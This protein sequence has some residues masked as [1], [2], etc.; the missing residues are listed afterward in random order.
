M[1]GPSPKVQR[2]AAD[3][4]AIASVTSEILERIPRGTTP[5]EFFGGLIRRAIDEILTLNS[6]RYRIEQLD[7][8]EQTYIG[9]RAEIL[10]KEALDVG[11]GLRADALIAE[12]EVDLKWSKRLDWM[13]G[14]ENLGTV[15]LGIGTDPL[16]KRFSVGLFVPHADL[17][18][19]QNRDKKYTAGGPFR[20]AN[21][22]WIVDQEPLPPNFIETLP[23]AI[24]EDIMSQGSAQERIR[25]LAELVPNTPIPR[26][27]IRFVSLNKDDFMRRIRVDK[28]RASPPLGEMVCLSWKYKKAE[29]SRLGL[30][31]KKDEFVF[32][33][34]ERLKE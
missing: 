1:P 2:D 8:P 4:A 34:G 29:L 20:R 26:A 7:A 30:S 19:G 31:L 32:V 3:A 23:D 22:R 16:Q 25:R 5:T 28:S 17:L 24:R 13:I 18:K 11:N 21:V 6:K 27:A 14:P 12:H 33:E 10:V 15:C 9:T